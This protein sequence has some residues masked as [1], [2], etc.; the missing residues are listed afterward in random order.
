MN[1]KIFKLFTTFLC[2]IISLTFI[3]GSI[4]A[5]NSEHSQSPQLD[6]VL[7]SDEELNR[8]LEYSEEVIEQHQ[9]Y[10]QANNLDFSEEAIQ[11]ALKSD[12][13][14]DTIVKYS[15]ALTEEEEQYVQERDQIMKKYGGQISALL[16]EGGLEVAIGPDKDIIETYS[17]IGTFHQET[18]NGLK[19]IVG[20]SV[21]NEK[22]K[23]VR[24]A[25]EELV[26]QEYL[27]IRKVNYSEAELLTAYEAI[28]KESRK[29]GIPFETVVVRVQENVVEV[30][31][32]KNEQA[33]Q[34][35]KGETLVP[36]KDKTSEIYKVVVEKSNE[37]LVARTSTLNTMAG[38]L[39]IA[40]NAS[41]SQTAS[42]IYCTIGTLAKKNNNRFIV[43]AAHCTEQWTSSIYQ[44][45]EEVGTKHFEYQGDYADVG[46]IAVASNKKISNY[47]YKYSWTDSRVTSY[48]SSS[49]SLN[50]GDK[51]CMSGATSGFKCGEVTALNVTSLG[52]LGYME[53]DIP[54]LGGDSGGT[55]WYDGNLLGI[56]RSSDYVSY[57]R[58]THIARAMAYGGA[59]T[60]FTSNTAE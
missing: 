22:V 2:V 3:S 32:A 12:N 59:L 38:G 37:Q 1:K 51:I 31:V 4:L 25:I 21:D 9:K 56:M 13:A 50:V 19:F 34:L 40:D 5:D 54:A 52:S 42:G 30:K 33:L 15:V 27:E 48:Q 55:L 47:V 46:V 8:Q 6:I 16:K 28:I 18:A 53:T 43:T 11:A 10:R 29:Q 35:L 49:S 45:G 17:N 39:L 41:N 60:P 58:F 26:P 24:K 44:G 20:F 14:K 7:M 57:S 23:Q 36:F